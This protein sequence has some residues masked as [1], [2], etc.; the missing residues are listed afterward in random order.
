MNLLISAQLL[1]EKYLEVKSHEKIRIEKKEFHEI[2][3]SLNK[4][5]KKYNFKKFKVKQ[6][7]KI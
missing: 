4:L 3:K 1:K 7:N 5:I 2:K 6:Q